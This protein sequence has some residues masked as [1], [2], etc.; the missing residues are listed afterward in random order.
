M[1]ESIQHYFNTHPQSNEC[2]TTSDGF[3]FHKE[4]DAQS[5]GATLKDKEVENH[6]REEKPLHPELVELI[7]RIK[8]EKFSLGTEEELIRKAKR[9]FAEAPM[10]NEPEQPSM[11][12]NN[13]ATAAPSTENAP[14]AEVTAQ[15]TPTVETGPTSIEAAPSTAGKKGKK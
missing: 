9:D 6:K 3:I 15:P 2:F 4:H 10:V 12:V 11:V 14:N 1:K 13:D 8:D 7:N 5:H